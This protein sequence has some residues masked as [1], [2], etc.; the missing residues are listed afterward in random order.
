MPYFFTHRLSGRRLTLDAKRSYYRPLFMA[1]LICNEAS[2]WEC[3]P[4][5]FQL[6]G[7]HFATVLPMP[8]AV[9]FLAREL[10]LSRSGAGWAA[11][12]FAVHPVHFGSRC[13]GFGNVGD[14]TDGAAN[15][16]GAHLL[17]PSQKIGGRE[18]ARRFGRILPACPF[19]KKKRRL[20]FQCLRFLAEFLQP[21]SGRKAVAFR[22]SLLAA[23]TAVYLVARTVFLGSMARE[24]SFLPWKTALPATIHFG[25]ATFYPCRHLLFPVRPEASSTTTIMWIL[26]DP[27]SSLF[28]F[29]SWLLIVIVTFVARRSGWLT[30]SELFAVAGL[31]CC[32]GPGTRFPALCLA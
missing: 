18:M 14:I 17:S 30:D 15:D 10:R 24:V 19:G 26:P 25:F 16:G 20:Y 1:V 31:F 12:L 32:S 4:R 5:A 3:I 21:R 27:A 11:L 29:R 9:L 22:L 7:Q 28:H 6:P 2:C 23:I 13:V 8:L